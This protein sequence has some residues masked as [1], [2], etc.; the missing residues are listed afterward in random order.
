ME[1]REGPSQCEHQKHRSLHTPPDTLSRCT[2]AMSRPVTVS[3]PV[4]CR[5]I[6]HAVEGLVVHTTLVDG[7]LGAATDGARDLCS[8]NNKAV[9][10]D[11]RSCG[12]IGTK[13]LSLNSECECVKELMRHL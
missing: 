9:L 4:F 10:S 8:P 11:V 7:R 2:D 13:Q 5:K 3:W 12:R 6:K 1:K